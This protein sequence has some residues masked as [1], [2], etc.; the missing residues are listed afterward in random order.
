M[1]HTTV[2]ENRNSE[3][4]SRAI[5]YYI[6]QNKPSRRCNMWEIPVKQFTGSYCRKVETF[7][8]K[9]PSEVSFQDFSII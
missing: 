7:S 9:I 5:N 8:K 6:F 2:D 4:V 3:H 1:L